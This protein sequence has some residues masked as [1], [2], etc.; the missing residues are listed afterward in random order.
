MYVHVQQT[1][2]NVNKLMKSLTCICSK[3]FGL[4]K[5][6]YYYLLNER[7]MASTYFVM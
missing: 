6:Y 3:V 7:Y 2:K 5:F 1:W 4:N